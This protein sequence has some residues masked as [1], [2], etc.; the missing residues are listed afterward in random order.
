MPSAS[1]SLAFM[2]VLVALY[3]LYV[4]HRKGEDSSYEALCDISETASCSRVLMSAYG[5]ILSKWGLVATGSALDLPNPVLGLAFYG[6]VLLRG[7]L[8][9]PRL[10]V[11]G[12][13][14]ASLAFS[15]YLAYILATVLKDLCIVC[16]SSYVVNLLI[17]IVEAR[18]ALKEAAVGAK[19]ARGAA[20]GGGGAPA[21]A[22]AAARSARK[23]AKRAD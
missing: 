6:M 20:A 11:L 18:G 22:S 1:S 8:R 9:L 5:H 3:A 13:S 14:A 19:S 2:G 4:E 12:A 7:A 21:S 23:G 15:L 10:A 17:F 16:V